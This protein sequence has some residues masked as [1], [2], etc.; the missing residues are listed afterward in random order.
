MVLQNPPIIYMHP[1]VR[2]PSNHTVECQLFGL[3][4]GRQG[5]NDGDDDNTM[6]NSKHIW[7]STLTKLH[8]LSFK[9]NSRL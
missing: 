4:V 1:V 6:D 9:I 2:D 7:P 5:M 3:M 8:N